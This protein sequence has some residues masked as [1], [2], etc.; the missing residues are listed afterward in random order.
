MPEEGAVQ[1]AL[2]LLATAPAEAFASGNISGAAPEAE[3]LV[4]WKSRLLVAAVVVAPRLIEVDENSAPSTG[5][6]TVMTFW[7]VVAP[8][9]TTKVTADDR[10]PSEPL[11]VT[12]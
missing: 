5:S 11:A 3:A 6:V 12:V 7:V 9:S 8:R 10:A 4:S 2:Q 1:L